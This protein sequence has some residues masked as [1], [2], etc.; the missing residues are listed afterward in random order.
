MEDSTGQPTDMDL[1]GDSDKEEGKDEEEVVSNF[2]Q[3]LHALLFNRFAIYMS[4]LLSR[5]KI[6]YSC[7]GSENNH[8]STIV[9]HL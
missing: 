5:F 1:E 3:F 7:W 8:Q 9:I 4:K 6:G 2:Y